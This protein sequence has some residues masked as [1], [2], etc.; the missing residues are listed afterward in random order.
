[1]DL[2]QK[3]PKVFY[4]WYVTGACLL[5][6]LY[7]AGVSHFGFTAVLDPIAE[8]FGWS[9]AQI[10]LATSLRGFE[11]G[12]LAP[13]MGF[14]VD[15][16][17]PRILIST[18]SIFTCAG[19]LLFSRASSLSMFYS[20]F[21]LIA[22]GMSTCTQTVLM[23]AVSNWFRRKAG[24]AIG[25]VATGFGLGGL[26]VPLIT[27]LTD[28]FYWRVAMATVGVGMLV[29]IIPLSLLVRHK[30]ENYGYQ[31]D[32]ETSRPEETMEPRIPANSVEVSIPARQAV[33]NRAFWHVALTAMCHSLV[34]GAVVTHLMPYLGSLGIAR[35]LSSLVAL[36]LPVASIPGRLSS[37][38]LADRY[39]SRS[40]LTTSFAFM[41][42]GMLFFWYVT[43]GRIWL[44][45]PFILAF[46][47]G[48]GWSVTT[49]ISLLRE[50][51]GRG[52]FGTILGLV[53]GVMMLGS[54]SGA[55]LAG[56]IFD[57]WGSYKGAWLSFSTL[58]ITATVL[59]YTIPPANGKN[60]RSNQPV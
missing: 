4:G 42:A 22:I 53:S 32:G 56:L 10:S 20:A 51:F 47:L 13:L 25:I 33:R 43:S 18:G 17:G 34:S 45:V 3:N 29:I 37:G 30:P 12:L 36:I 21:V 5:I 39:G 27:G 44:L 49:R 15:R 59:A 14:L 28:V 16:W 2:E 11:I 7:S 46:S 6:T 19:F 23:T 41:T 8:E 9:Y 54:I 57:I 24:T 38:W 48:W 1:M 26:L 55:P 58:T 31:L 52:S 35:T 60:Q 50:Y 40:I